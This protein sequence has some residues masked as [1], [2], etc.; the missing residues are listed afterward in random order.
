[1]VFNTLPVPKNG[2]ILIISGVIL[3]MLV[4]FLSPHFAMLYLQPVHRK[5]FLTNIISGSK[6]SLT[7]K[8]PLKKLFSYFINLCLKSP[9]QALCSASFS[10]FRGS[11]LIVFKKKGKK[12]QK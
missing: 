9:Y 10:Q 4:N 12:G 8:N 7:V 1:M 2:V 11:L 5:T 3:S 6:T